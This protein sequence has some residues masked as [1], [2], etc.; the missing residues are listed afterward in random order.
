[1]WSLESI[2]YWENLCIDNNYFVGRGIW[3]VGDGGLI[4]GGV[5]EEVNRGGRGVGGRSGGDQRSVGG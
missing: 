5:T 3:G 2:V 1:M 4:G